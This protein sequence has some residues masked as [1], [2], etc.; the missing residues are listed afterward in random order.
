MTSVMAPNPTKKLGNAEFGEFLMGKRKAAG[1]T[2]YDLADA[3]GIS[4]PYVSQLE[5]GYRNPSASVVQALSVAL[6]LDAGEVLA[7]A[8]PPDMINEVGTMEMLRNTFT[9]HPRLISPGDRVTVIDA[10]VD[11][12][13]MHLTLNDGT[14]ITLKADRRA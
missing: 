9:K 1:M 13:V 3:C 6:S 14:T 2:R 12:P 8:F 4:Y 11:G 7:Q 5:T 10:V